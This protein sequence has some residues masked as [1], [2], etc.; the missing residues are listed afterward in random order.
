MRTTL[1]LPDSLLTEAKL[2]A[3]KEGISLKELFTRALS[4]EIHG[5]N[6]PSQP[7][8]WKSLQGSGSSTL[9]AE[10]SGFDGY[11]GPDWVQSFMVNED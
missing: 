9:S 2:K 11:S 6:A 10:T 8:P 3:V 4:H 1:D 7:A 5:G